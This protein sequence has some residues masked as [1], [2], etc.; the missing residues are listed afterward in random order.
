[1]LEQICWV[2]RQSC[3][4][5]LIKLDPRIVVEL[6]SHQELK[7]ES[8]ESIRMPETSKIHADHQ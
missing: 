5:P 7:D 1:M 2:E 4:A 3:T 6:T 8:F